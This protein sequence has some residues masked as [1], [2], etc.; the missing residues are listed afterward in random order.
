MAVAVTWAVVSHWILGVPLDV[1]IR[2]RRA[3]SPARDD[4]MVLFDVH[5]RRFNMIDDWIGTFVIALTAFVLSAL[6][7]FGFY[8]GVELAQG[9]FLLGF[10]LT[11]VGI[12]CQRACRR[13]AAE[14]PSSDTLAAELL[15][16]RIV[17]QIIA[18]IAVFFTAA[19]GMYF[20]L[21]LPMGF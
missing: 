1:I 13:F 4:L 17:I 15:R 6:A 20:N 8:Y 16:L 11:I 7:L 21:I 10:P 2:A 9:L 18:A 5:V 12:I 14:P 3:G 19:Y